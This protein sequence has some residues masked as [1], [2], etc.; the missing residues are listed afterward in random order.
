MIKKN[1]SEVIEF[2]ESLPYREVVCIFYNV[3]RKFND[4]EFIDGQGLRVYSRSV[5]VEAGYLVGEKHPEYRAV[6]LPFHNYGGFVSDGISQS[7]CCSNCGAICAGFSKGAECPVC[8][9][10]VD[11]T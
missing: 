6:A 3:M 4:E 8:G 9:N 11:M 2:L 5:V 10:E 7:G 1:S